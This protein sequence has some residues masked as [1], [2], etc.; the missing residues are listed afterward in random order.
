MKN[1]SLLVLLLGTFGLANA[2]QDTEVIY[3]DD[4]DIMDMPVEVPPEEETPSIFVIVEDMPQYPGGDLELTTFIQQHIEYPASAK[5]K[6]QEGRV[7]V[8]FVV[9]ETGEISNPIVTRG[10]YEAL[11]DEA[12]RVVSLLPDFI[13]GKQRGKPVK[14]YKTVPVIFKLPK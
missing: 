13:P 10:E 9:N 8:K 6:K 1:L 2:Q 5:A 11:N 4:E 7:L 12:V 3:L 14:V